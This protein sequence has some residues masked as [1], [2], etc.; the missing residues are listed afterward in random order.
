VLLVASGLMLRS[1]RAL[2]TVQ[3]GFSRP[4]HVQTLRITLPEAQVAEPERVARMQ[5]NIVERIAEIH[6][7]DSVAFATALPMEAEFEI[8][9]TI[10]VEGV[11]D[12]GGIPPLRRTKFVAPGVFATL[13]I[14]LVAG[15]D[16]TWADIF[17]TRDVAIVSE[18]MARET[19]GSPSAALGKHIRAGRVGVLKEIVGVVGDVYDSGVHREAPTI[20]YWRVGVQRF[21]LNLPDYIPRDATL[22]IRSDRTGSDDFL[23]QVRGAVWAVNPNLPVSRVRTLADVY[24]QSM[25]RTSF[26][27]VMLAIAGSMALVLSIIGI[28]G[29]VSYAVSQR[30]REIGIR[31]ALGAQPAEI[32]RLFVRRS[33]V[34]VALGAVIGLGGAAGCTRLMQSLLFGTSPLDPITFAAMPVILAATA[35]VASYLSTRRA[36]AIDPVETLRAP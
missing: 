20:V 31:L 21:F 27:L 25:S 2:R 6:G 30:G 13:G 19:W 15:R 24:A 10:S 14:P 1:F 16:F 22:A 9:T 5:A 17:N 36:V 18:N 23:Q 35:V 11:P 28:Y 32:R 3:P 29:V 33:V 8:D 26:T 12:G 4:D 7:V 34:V